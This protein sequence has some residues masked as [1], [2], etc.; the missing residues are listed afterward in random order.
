MDITVKNVCTF[1]TSSSNGHQIY[2][3]K[4]FQEGD[5]SIKDIEQ[6]QHSKN[7]TPMSTNK[8]QVIVPDGTIIDIKV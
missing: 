2:T 1:P 7:I 8:L 5:V 4:V 3:D 6:T